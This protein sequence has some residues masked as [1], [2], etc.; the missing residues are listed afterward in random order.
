MLRKNAYK[1]VTNLK[2]KIIQWLTLFSIFLLSSIFAAK[3]MFSA[4]IAFTLLEI[5]S[6]SISSFS[7]LASGTNKSELYVNQVQNNRL[8]CL[9]LWHKSCNN[10]CWEAA[11]ELRVSASSH[12]IIRYIFESSKNGLIHLLNLK[13]LEMDLFVGKR[14]TQ[15]ISLRFQSCAICLHYKFLQ[16]IQFNTR[17]NTN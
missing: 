6:N 15:S 10:V 17:Q 2:I 14:L 16:L 3:T 7:L 4:S 1:E 8:S 11:F 12:L 9:L 5:F 13:F